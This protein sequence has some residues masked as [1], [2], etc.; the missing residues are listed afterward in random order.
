V[1][2]SAACFDA[3]AQ[4][5][6]EDDLAALIAQARES[7]AQNDTDGALKTLDRVIAKDA[8]NQEARKLRGELYFKIGDMDKAMADFAELRT[9]Q[10]A[11]AVAAAPRPPRPDWLPIIVERFRN[12]SAEFARGSFDAAIDHYNAILAMD[13]PH[14]TASTAVQNRGNAYRAKRDSERALRDFEQA[15]RLDPRNAGAYVNRGSILAERGDHDAAVL[16]YNEAIRFDPKIA[17]AF[18][19]RGVSF[20]VAERWEAALRDFNE[21][22]RLAPKSA[23]VRAR[24]G[25][26]FMM[27][28]KA[29]QARADFQAASRLDPE[30]P[31]GW[32]GLARLDQ[33]AGKFTAVA[34]NLEK[35]IT[36]AP[37]NAGLLN[38]SAWLQA[39]APTAA[40]RD[41][42]KAV[43]RALKACELTEWREFGYV[44]TLAAA[45]AEVGDFDKAVDF[46]WYALSLIAGEEEHPNRVE[47]EERLALFQRREKY[48]EAKPRD[49]TSPGAPAKK[50]DSDATPT[51]PSRPS[52]GRVGMS[53]PQ[54]PPSGDRADFAR[55]LL[56]FCA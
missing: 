17:E 13:V 6:P 18:Y 19:N 4:N 35:A 14:Q 5:A 1:L 30:S 32:V 44:D 45:Y 11:S 37:D 28:G 12:A 34:A 10:A 36:R 25:E 54:L 15:I 23:G 46:Q 29:K 22:I 7:A 27:Q 16:D 20:A 38:F 41:G 33:R 39:T 50:G 40:A 48:R 47:A 51:P 21:A 9:E 55:A 2:L 49:D 52:D 24:R 8:Q 42:K 31:A 53:S 43:A 26:L 3:S 56:R